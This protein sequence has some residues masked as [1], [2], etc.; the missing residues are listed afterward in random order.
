MKPLIMITNDDGIYSEG[1][2][3][4]ILAAVPM[5]DV[6]VAAPK[7]QQTAMGRAYPRTPDLGIIESVDLGIDGAEAYAVHGSPGQCA[8][9]GILEIADR[10]PDILISGINFGCNLGMSLTCSG[11]LGAAFEAYSEGIPVL[12]V[13]LETKAEEIMVT[14]SEKVGF[15]YAAKITEKWIRRMLGI[16]KG[17]GAT[18]HRFLNINIPAGEIDVDS[19]RYTFLEA[20][21]YYVLKRPAKRDWRKPFTMKFE[22]EIDEEKLHPGSDIQTVCQDR[23]TSVTPIAMDMTRN[24]MSRF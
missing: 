16:E 15:Q 22:I 14:A 18:E 5:G 3:A 2:R 1:L 10:K 4:A 17:E 6:L 12:A 23:L 9:Y 13:S 24:A 11:T 8:A 19:Y 21:N 7:Q 20:Q